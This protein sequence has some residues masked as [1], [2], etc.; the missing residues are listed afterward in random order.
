MIWTT[1]VVPAAGVSKNAII[2]YLIS[3]RSKQA[4]FS[5]KCPPIS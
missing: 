5:L 3:K 1:I 2:R 4:N